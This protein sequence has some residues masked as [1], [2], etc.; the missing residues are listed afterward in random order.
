MTLTLKG[1]YRDGKIELLNPPAELVENQ[2]VE[3]TIQLE[4]LSEEGQKE[5]AME[6]GLAII[7]MM[8][9]LPE[10]QLAAFDEVMADRN[11]PFFGDRE[12]E[13]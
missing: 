1:V 12:I 4:E 11:R 2:D 13:W 8:N 10:D 7:G 5:A 9:T 3:V 6:A